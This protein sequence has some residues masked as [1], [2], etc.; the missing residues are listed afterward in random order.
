MSKL[1]VEIDRE[2]LGVLKIENH[3][4]TVIFRLDDKEMFKVTVETAKEIKKGLGAI[5]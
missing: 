1:N 3:G 2:E 4:S 5:L